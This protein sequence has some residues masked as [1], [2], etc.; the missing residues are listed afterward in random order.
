MVEDS[1]PGIA[2]GERERAFSRFHR[3]NGEDESAAQA[4]CGLGLAIAERTCERHGATIDLGRSETLGGLRA[5][6]SFPAARG[7]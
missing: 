3:G 2:A 1:G 4:G 6:V 5:S 7:T